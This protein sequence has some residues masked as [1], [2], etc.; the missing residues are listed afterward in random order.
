VLER[1]IG[2]FRTYAVRSR[3]TVTRRPD[4]SGSKR[5][6]GCG[7]AGRL[8]PL[9]R[10]ARVSDGACS[11]RVLDLRAWMFMGGVHVTS[12]WAVRLRPHD[13]CDLLWCQRP[14]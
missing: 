10:R 7:C 8:V 13:R 12:M 11:I 3:H 1:F 2:N 9:G 4:R 6:D 5:S 14:R